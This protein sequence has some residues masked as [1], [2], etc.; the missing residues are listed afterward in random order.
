[1]ARIL[2][3][4]FSAIGDVAM[5]VPIVHSLALQYPLDE[6]V[7][8]SKESMRPLFAEM[9]TNV[10]FLGADV[11]NKHKGI[12][13]L[14]TL[15]GELKEYNFD[16]V[17]DLHNVLRSKYLTLRLRMAGSEVVTLQKGRKE[18]KKLIKANLEE[19]SAVKSSFARS[20][21]V[22][23]L[24]GFPVQA[25][26][27]SIYGDQKGD[28]SLI[29][30]IVGEKKTEK[31]VGIAPFAA[32]KGKVYPIELM[33]KVVAELSLRENTRIFLFGGGAKEKKILARWEQKYKPVESVVGKLQMN[34][35]LILMSHI[36]VML[37]MDSAN[38][39]LASL[40][41]TSVVSI[42]G[43]THPYG[44]FLGWKQLPT[45][46]IQVDLSC[47]PCSIYGNKPCKRGDYACLTSIAPT[48]VVHKIE[49]LIN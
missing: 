32:H 30:S 5:T 8:L 34:T 42:W 24:L 28:L 10:K 12:G 11:K 29:R 6:I 3:I 26:F 14:S 25:N 2:I 38:M 48:T 16:Y 41:N 40:V 46:A 27:V 49:T 33:E 7:M 17:A 31:W 23:K 21:E 22:F 15:Y 4:R 1:M 18:K 13:G 47:R 39:H 44:G 36:D 45:N 35:E 9:P 20:L 43:A 37:T 19:I